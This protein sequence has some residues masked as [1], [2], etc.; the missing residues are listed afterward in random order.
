[1]SQGFHMIDVGGKRVTHRVAIAEGCIIVGP[2]AF[3][4]IQT[5]SL[6]K[7]DVLVLADIAGIQGA[8]QASQ[9]I[10]LCHPMGLD[11]VQI[12]THLD[13]DTSCIRVTCLAATTAR[14][15]VEMEALAG[16]N[17]ALLTIWDLSKMIEPDLRIEGVRLLAK[18]GGKSGL[19]LNPAG[20]PDWVLERVMPPVTTLPL[21]GIPVAILVLSD[22]ASAG[23]YQDRSGPVAQAL[24]QAAGATITERCV[25][26]D[27]PD[28]LRHKILEIHARGDTR[29]LLTSGGTGIAP[30]D[31]TPDVVADLADRLLPGIGEQLRQYGAQFTPF[32]WS[33]RSV[34]ACLGQMLIVT[35]PG[36]PKAVQE[37]LECLTPQL[38]HLI[39]TL[40]DIKH[41]SV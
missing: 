40:D 41:D 2:Q 33:S 26:P 5:R 18:K 14:T 11:Q 27:D 1:M 31:R 32:S 22:R 30:R 23:A 20:V 6:P 38:P 36:S 8:K 15:G 29:L 4:L 17:A 3:S 28:Q 7:G 24:L 37:G 25:L 35:L 9:L 13:A 39:R 16:V 10:P 21:E 34:G 12:F 19:W